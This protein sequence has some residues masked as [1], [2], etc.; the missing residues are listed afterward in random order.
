MTLEDWRAGRLVGTVEQIREQVAGWAE[1]GV[2]TLILGVGAVPFHLG[3]ADDLD[4]LAS[5]VGASGSVAT[6]G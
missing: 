1:L 3:S 6:A 5:A 2:E 4:L